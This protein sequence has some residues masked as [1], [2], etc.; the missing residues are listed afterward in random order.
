MSLRYLDHYG[1]A[2]N[3][4]FGIDFNYIGVGLLGVSH[5]AITPTLFP[6]WQ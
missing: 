2:D 1:V 3:F 5:G 4:V 6:K